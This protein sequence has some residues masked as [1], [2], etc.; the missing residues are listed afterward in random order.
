MRIGLIVSEHTPPSSIAGPWDIFK[1]AAQLSKE[2]G[3]GKQKTKSE[4]KNQH[5]IVVIDVFSER[6]DLAHQM[7]F[8]V[9]PNASVGDNTVYDLLVICALGNVTEQLLTQNPLTISWLQHQAGK[10]AKLASICTGAFMLAATGLLDSRQATTHWVAAERF[11]KAFPA[12]D[13]KIDNTVTQDGQFYCSGGAFAY[14]DLC[15][16]LVFELFGERIADQCSRF[17]LI[18]TTPRH[19][20]AF[21]GTQAM[22]LHRDTKILKIQNWMER[23]VLDIESV[24]QIA[25]TFHLSNRHL[26]RR[27]KLLIGEPP[28]TYLQRLR[29]ELAKQLLIDPNKNVDAVADHVGYQDVQYFRSLFK[30]FTGVNPSVYRRQALGA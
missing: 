30:R 3:E 29:I 14:Q 15:L 13:L 7:P 8:V 21:A 17:L 12:V 23:Y 26:V 2:N 1:L 18:E 22:K 4:H 20:L 24:E 10:G 25:D 6:S 5:S 19:Q 27:F 9:T 28:S 16:H 11:R